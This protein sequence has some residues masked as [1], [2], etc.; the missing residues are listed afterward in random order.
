MRIKRAI[1]LTIVTLG[2]AGSILAS[3]GVPATAA[4][5]PAAHSVH[6]QGMIYWE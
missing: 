5:A 1:I 3:S 4:Q 2:A 6:S